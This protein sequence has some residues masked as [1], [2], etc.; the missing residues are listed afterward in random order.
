LEAAKLNKKTKAELD[1]EKEAANREIYKSGAA[2]VDL[3]NAE[4]TVPRV[5]SDPGYVPRMARGEASQYVASLPPLERSMVAKESSGNPRAIGP[6]HAKLGRPLGLGQVME[7]NL[8]QWSKEA[9]GRTVTPDEYLAN[10]KMQTDLIKHRMG[11]YKAKYG[12]EGALSM[13]F[14]GKP[15]PS[16][17]KDSL[18]TR[19]YD[20]VRDIMRGVRTSAVDPDEEEV[21]VVYAASGGLIP[22]AGLR[23]DS[24]SNPAVRDAVESDYDPR[25]FVDMGGMSEMADVG[26]RYLQKSFGLESGGISDVNPRAQEGM[27]AYAS[28][29]GAPS[30]DEV[31]TIKDTVDPKKKLPTEELRAIAGWNALYKHHTR[32]GNAAAAQRAAGAMLMYSKLAA[33]QAGT[34]ALAKAEDGDIVGAAKA[35]SS[36]YVLPDGNRIE[37]SGKGEKGAKFKIIDDVTGKVTDQGEA[38]MD[39]VVKLATGMANGTEFFRAAGVL[40]SKGGVDKVAARNEQERKA[41]EDYTRV[42]GAG[43]TAEFLESLESDE[44]REA[45]RKMPVSAQ[46]REV[47]AWQRQQ[48]EEA[49]AGRFETRIATAAEKERY[50]RGMK[51]FLEAQKQGNWEDARARSMSQADRRLSAYERD[52]SDRNVRHRESAEERRKRHEEI[53]RRILERGAKGTVGGRLTADERADQAIELERDPAKSAITAGV[54]VV[55]GGAEEYGPASGNIPM[56]AQALDVDTAFRKRANDK[57][58]EFDPAAA[59]E[60]HGLVA[61]QWKTVAKRDI[62]PDVHQ[63]L[64]DVAADITRGADVTPRRAAQIAIQAIQPGTPMQV[65]RDGRVQIGDQPPVMMSGRSLM[66]LA[67]LRGRQVRPEPNN[68]TSTAPAAAPASDRSAMGGIF[69]GHTPEERGGITGMNVNTIRRRGGALDVETASPTG[70]R[71][72]VPVAGVSSVHAHTTQKYDIDPQRKKRELRWMWEK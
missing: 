31:E 56:R 3:D 59:E 33:Q 55:E 22:D 20:Y 69:R 24:G 13:W 10:P 64:G 46:A 16:G 49:K 57:A 4:I 43:A 30:P 65:G 11:I 8:P 2:G 28:N 21:P 39:Q 45:F 40:A 9:F 41:V 61:D 19:D 29:V 36:G 37:V 35:V 68:K 67:R 52:L 6:R 15:T 48:S 42:A 54:D 63:S 72:A 5:S 14:T 50:N 53:D 62:A 51:A 23:E 71:S 1:A 38:T 47:S 27:R 58:N 12:D 66:E 34:M 26:I 18:G 32:N 44:A 17:K 70:N 25:E 7:A 60:V